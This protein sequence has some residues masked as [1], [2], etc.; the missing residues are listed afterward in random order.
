MKLKIS[1][2][3]VCDGIFQ[4]ASG[5][6]AHMLYH[7]D[8]QNYQVV[9]TSGSEYIARAREVRSFLSEAKVGQWLFYWL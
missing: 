3:E 7:E 4:R 6:T 2:T 5:S 1:A 8:D 9:Y